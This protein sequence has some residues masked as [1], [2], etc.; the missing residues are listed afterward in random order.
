MEGFRV[1]SRT[2][3]QITI[4]FDKSHFAQGYATEFIRDQDAKFA[5][6]EQLPKTIR[7]QINKQVVDL[8]K[9][10]E[11]AKKNKGKEGQGDPEGSTPGTKP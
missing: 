7:D 2:N 3:Y 10:Y 8:I 11:E 6:I 1:E 5:K 4:Q 9:Q